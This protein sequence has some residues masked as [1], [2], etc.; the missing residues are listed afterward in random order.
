VV[1]DKSAYWHNRY[2][3]ANGN[4]IWGSRSTLRFVNGQSNADVLQPEMLQI[5]V[6]TAN[7]DRRIWAVAAGGSARRR[8][9]HA[10]EPVEVISNV[11]GGSKSSSA[12]KEGT[13]DYTSGEAAIA[14]MTLAKGFEVGPVRRRG[15]FSRI[16]QPGADR[17]G[18]ASG[19]LWVAAWKTY[20]SWKPGTSMDDRLL[21][22]PDENRDGRADRC[23][24]FARVHNPT[25]FEFWNGGVLVASAPELLFLKDT[26]GD[27]VADVRINLLQGIEAA[28]THHAANSFV[29]GPDGA[30]YWQRGVFI[31]ENVETPWGAAKASGATGMYRFDP[32]RYTFGFHAPIGPNPHG[33]SFDRWGYHF[34][35]DGTSGNPFQVVPSP[36]G[37][38]MRELFKKTVRPVPASGIVSSQ[39][40]PPEN[41]Q[42][43]SSAT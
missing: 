28:D 35:T 40:F 4:D 7:R 38:E 24:T 19:R 6:L 1:R 43:F 39:Q 2:R 22:L 33:I 16:G 41:Q 15:A 26:D 27:D 8:S 23:I 5:D 11:G 3:A 9:E 18:P 14:H 17:H 20:P 37:F 32:R 30:L 42:N 10:S 25:G 21:I 31:V 29:Y 13:S 12:M 36:K 34:A